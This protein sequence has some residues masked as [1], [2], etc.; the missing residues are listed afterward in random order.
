MKKNQIIAIAIVAVVAIAGISIVA[1]NMTKKDSGHDLV[2]ANGNK[3]C[4]EPTWLADQL[5]Y[6]KEFGA[7][8]EMLQVT[9]GGKA[10]EALQS[11]RADIA[12][13][14]STPLAN[15]L[16]K[17]VDDNIVVLGR[18]MGGKNYSEM[19]TKVTSDGKVYDFNNPITPSL[20]TVTYFDGSTADITTKPLKDSH[21]KIGMDTSTGY[22]AAITNYCKVTGLTIGFPG[23][24]GYESKDVCVVHVEFGNQVASLDSGEVDAIMGGSYDLAAYATLD[25]CVLSSPSDERYPS[26][27]SEATCVLAATKEAYATKYDQIVGVLKALQKAC[28]YIYGIDYIDGLYL[29]E[30]IIKD[31]Q[32][33]MSDAKK[34]ELFGDS[35]IS[36]NGY[37]Y[38]TDSCKRIAD[39]FGAPFTVDVQR[40]SYDKYVWA[41]DFELIDMK[42]VEATYNAS[43]TGTSSF[44]TL[45]SMDYMNYFDGRALYDA[46]KDSNGN[47]SWDMTSWYGDAP[48]Y[49]DTLYNHK[50]TFTTAEDTYKLFVDVVDQQWTITVAKANGTPYGAGTV[51]VTMDGTALP[52]DAF[53]YDSGT[54]L[55][56]LKVAVTGNVV[57]TV[58]TP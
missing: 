57:V 31:K 21:I 45:N 15:Q 2:F 5:G 36:A 49:F 40:L 25:K 1:V 29:D 43:S 23:E 44:R 12:G 9:G 13:Y 17:N 3:D 55:L 6:Y 53:E 56:T 50:Y 24:A 39:F 58:A 28:C 20:I 35:T 30:D 11:G 19:A 16:N 22:K 51:T 4:Y 33:A 10:L 38:T 32:A 34:K 18:W 48:I 26:L 47:S 7:D 8:V 54:S 42:I 14:G 27:V 37:Y 41:I 52:A 46:L